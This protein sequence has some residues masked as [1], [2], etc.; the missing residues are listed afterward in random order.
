MFILSPKIPDLSIVM[1]CSVS[2]VILCLSLEARMF[3][4]AHQAEK[5]H[6]SVLHLIEVLQDSKEENQEEVSTVVDSLVTKIT[7]VGPMTGGG[8]F[9]IDRRTMTTM[10]GATLTYLIVLIQFKTAV[11]MCFQYISYKTL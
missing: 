2:S 7:M 11:Y 10:F 8:M 3:H 6:M 1:V 5:V 4:I 9:Y